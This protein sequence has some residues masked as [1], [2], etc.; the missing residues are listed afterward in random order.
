MWNAMLLR[1]Q[2]RSF[3]QHSRTLLIK[4]EEYRP[5][6]GLATCQTVCL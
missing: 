4:H 3:C 1:R 2:G 6:H 5:T